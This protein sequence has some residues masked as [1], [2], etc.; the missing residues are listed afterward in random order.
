MILIIIL[1]HLA[2]AYQ[3]SCTTLRKQDPALP[4]NRA[5]NRCEACFNWVWIVQLTQHCLYMDSPRYTKHSY[6]H[7]DKNKKKSG[8]HTPRTALNRGICK[9]FG[10]AKLIQWTLEWLQPHTESTK[11]TWATNVVNTQPRNSCIH[12]CELRKKVILLRS[13]QK[14]VLYSCFRSSI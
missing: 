3:R 10:G 13:G 8:L 6:K 5:L 9:F 1:C 7:Q 4:E 11:Y 12:A 14:T 2:W